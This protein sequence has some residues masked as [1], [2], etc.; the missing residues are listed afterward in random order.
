MKLIEKN[1]DFRYTNLGMFDLI[2]GIALVEIMLDHA[3]FCFGWSSPFQKLPLMIFC[4]NTTIPLFLLASG[5]GFRKA[6]L[7]KGTRKQAEY[8]MK[9]YLYAGIGYIVLSFFVGLSFRPSLFK[10]FTHAAKYAIGMLLGLSF[11]LHIKGRLIGHGVGTTWYLLTLFLCWV[12][13]DFLVNHFDRKKV[14]FLVAGCVIEGSVV[15]SFLNLPWCILQALIGVGYYYVGWRLKERKFF[16]KP[17]SVVTLAL[18]FGSAALSVWTG[19]YN[20]ATCDWRYGL[21][22]IIFACGAGLLLVWL[23]VRLNAWEFPGKAQLQWLGRNTLILLSI[24]TVEDHG[25][26]WNSIA[27]WLDRTSIVPFP[28]LLLARVALVFSGYCI[29][30]YFQSILKRKSK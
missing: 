13:L 21:P 5:Y 10:T 26:P 3:L 1:K 27:D 12:L 15:G 30:R 18:L 4:H 29:V 19:W 8:L 14:P 11:E 24:H 23:G 25:F 17:F 2:K 16:Q 22:E 6:D 20:L 9:P 7:R 28:V